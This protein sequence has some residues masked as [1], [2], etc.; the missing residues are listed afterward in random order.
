VSHFAFIAPPLTGH[1][2]PMAALA[3][4]LVSRG[5]GATFVHQSSA[6]ALAALHGADFV[7][8]TSSPLGEHRGVAGTIREV[9]RQTDMLCHHAPDVLREINADAVITDQLEPAGGLLAD[10]LGLPCITVA[11]ALPINREPGV[12][13]PYVGWNYDP[14]PRGR[15]RNNGGWRITDRLMRPVS[16][17][18]QRHSESFNLRPRRRIEDCFSSLLQLAQAVPLIDFPRAE[19]PENFHYLGPFRHGSTEA[20]DLPGRDGRPLA[21]CSFGT[22]QG[23]RLKLFAKVSAA[24]A[25]LG[26]QLVIA[27]CGRLTPRQV[28]ALPGNPLVF[29]Y[30]PQEELLAEARLVITHAGFNTV[31]ETLARGLP[32]LALPIAFDQPAIGARIR[33]AGVGEV[34]SPRRASAFR[35][36]KSM[37]RIMHEPLFEQQAHKVQ[38]QIAAAGG[39]KRAADLVEASLS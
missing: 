38:Q 19:L 29:D 32:M 24:C 39:V 28:G 1:Y 27:H 34:I 11:S 5:H 37:K 8:L 25:N 21:F 23:R 10:Y 31:L 22:L 12:P 6:R 3:R 35:L 30:L 17:V 9:A 26:L 14:S 16:A 15:W 33:H 20:F 13:P 7:P 2:K 4:E 36:R 18:I